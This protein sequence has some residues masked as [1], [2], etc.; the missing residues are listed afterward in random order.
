MS[1]SAAW[2]ENETRPALQRSTKAAL[3]EALEEDAM[4]ASATP[5]VFAQA[6]THIEPLG[7]TPAVDAIEAWA[8]AGSVSTVRRRHFSQPSHDVALPSSHCSPVF[9]PPMP[10]ALTFVMPVKSGTA[11]LYRVRIGPM[12]DRESAEAALRTVKSPGARIVAHP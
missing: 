5:L 7:T 9:T 1:S 12:K 6:S 2:L 4:I 11:T 8:A 10:H 3:S